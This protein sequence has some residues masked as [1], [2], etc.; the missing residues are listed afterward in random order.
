MRPLAEGIDLEKYYDIYDISVCDIREAELSYSENEYEDP[1]A[2]KALKTYLY[3]L[4][5]TR[6][7]ILCCLLALEADGGKPD[8]PRWTAAVEQLGELNAA[9][10]TVSEK[11]SRILSEEERKSVT[12]YPH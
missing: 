5:V 2:L 11:V 1:E 12:T 6:K 4:L 10:A 7:M 8:F 3:R 9:T